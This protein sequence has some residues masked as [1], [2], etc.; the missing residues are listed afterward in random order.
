MLIR[1]RLLATRRICF[2]FLGGVFYGFIL[3]ASHNFTFS[4]IC[5]CC[6]NFT[7]FVVVSFHC[8]IMLYSVVVCLISLSRWFLVFVV[9]GVGCWSCCCSPTIWQS[10]Y[11]TIRAHWFMCTNTEV[12]AYI[13]MWSFTNYIVANRGYIYCCM[14]LLLLVVLLLTLLLGM[15]RICCSND[16]HCILAVFCC[17]LLLTTPSYLPL[18]GSIFFPAC[19]FLFIFT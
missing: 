8:F 18:C 12:C 11:F 1:L 19:L 10:V 17:C 2:F 9:L 5:S 16:W 6:C 13:C 15:P 14:H 3:L 7:L 4:P